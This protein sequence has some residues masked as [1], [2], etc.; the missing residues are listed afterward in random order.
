MKNLIIIICIFQISL[1]SCEKKLDEIEKDTIEQ[2][3][4]EQ[5]I[6]AAQNNIV[7]LWETSEFLVNNTWYD[8]QD[9]LTAA[10]NNPNESI[11]YLTRLNVEEHNPND[12]Y[13]YGSSS[14]NDISG[15]QSHH[16]YLYSNDSISLTPDCFS[17]GVTY[18]Y[19]F[20]YEFITNDELKLI[21]ADNFRSVKLLRQ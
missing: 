6:A 15:G 10:Q 7:G 12:I 5:A 19:E 3:D 8:I 9:D 4:E 11:L 20:Q 14:T 18:N 2:D 13:R 16:I 21:S 17:C 1:S